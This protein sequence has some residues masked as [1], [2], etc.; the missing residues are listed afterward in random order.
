MRFVWLAAWIL[1]IIIGGFLL[2]PVF[3]GEWLNLLLYIPAFFI[4]TYCGIKF[5][6]YK[7]DNS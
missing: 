7:R 2:G 1:W 6:N 5:F 4:A 3:R